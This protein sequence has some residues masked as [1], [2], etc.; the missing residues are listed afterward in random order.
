MRKFDIVLFNGCK[1]LLGEKVGTGYKALNL[2]KPSQIGSGKRH[3]TYTYIDIRD[4]GKCQFVKRSSKQ[5]REELC[6]P[7][8]FC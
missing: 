7:E 2:D 8:S 3:F 6:L 1:H 4:L 5:E